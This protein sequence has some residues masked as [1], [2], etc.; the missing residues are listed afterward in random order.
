MLRK[1]SILLLLLG[2]S[3]A[4]NMLDGTNGYAADPFAAKKFLWDATGAQMEDNADWVIDADVHNLRCSG[5]CGTGGNESNPQRYPTPTIPETATS[6][7][8]GNSSW[9]YEIFR[10]GHSVE[11]LP[12]NGKI[13]YGNSSYN[14]DLSNYDV[15]ITVEPNRQ[16]SST[17]LAAI[18]A[19]VEN[20][21]GLFLITNHVIADRNN[22]GWSPPEIG[23][24]ISAWTGISFALT[25]TDADFTEDPNNNISSDTSDPIM[26]GPFGAGSRGLGLFGATTLI[27]DSSVNATVQA[28]A[29]RNGQPQTADNKVTFATA[30]YGQGRI[31]SFGDSATTD[32]DTGDPNDELTNG[33]N[34]YSDRNILLN[35][36]LWLARSGKNPNPDKDR[37]G[38]PD[39]DDNCPSAANADQLDSDKDGLGDACDPEDNS[40]CAAR[41]NVVAPSSQ[42]VAAFIMMIGLGL[43]AAFIRRANKN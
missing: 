22:D 6:W 41:A 24:Q 15:F 11:T 8:G 23:N 26:R 30:E 25:G 29:W 34:D 13:S 37:D 9:A 12:Y 42:P 18:K 1:R 43:T 21:G 38:I 33:Y 19:F 14:L 32:D 36:C 39:N 31:A 10:E 28:H 40:P 5:K 35:T 4:W 3:C 17:E 2:L 16:W 27:I 20:G 7:T